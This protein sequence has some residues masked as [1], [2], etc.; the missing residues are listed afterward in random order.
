MGPRALSRLTEPMSHGLQAAPTV[1]MQDSLQTIYDNR[2]SGRQ[3]YRR[4]V[5]AMLISDFFSRY[6]TADSAVLDL[7]CGYGEFI[8]QIRTRI[9]YG[10]DL[11]PDSQRHLDPGVRLFQQDCSVRWPI[12]D[13]T[14]DLV[15]TSNFFEHLP[16][17]SSLAATLQEARRCLRPG[18]RLVALGP[19]IKY[20]PGAYWDF[21]DHYLPLTEASLS[22]GLETAGFHLEKVV[23]RFLPYTMSKGVRYPLIFL[24][25]YLR[26]PFAWPF[27]G[28]QFLVVAKK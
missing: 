21:W 3:D 11:N 23:A 1:M 13:N 27:F 10:M 28:R 16:D 26:L 5:W 24:R 9:R 7:G 22:E 17:K 18:G 25:L 15:F 12:P 4:N 8:N 19:N 20:L 14:L 6:F 2:F